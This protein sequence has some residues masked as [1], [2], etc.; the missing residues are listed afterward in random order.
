MPIKSDELYLA[1]EFGKFLKKQFGEDIVF[2]HCGAP[3]RAG[4]FQRVSVIYKHELV[5]VV[6]KDD[7]SVMYVGRVPSYVNPKTGK[8]DIALEQH[9]F[10]EHKR[11]D[12]HLGIAFP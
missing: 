6:S 11:V 2:E 12:G 4:Q 7:L 1:P 10:G 9:L 3:Y 5:G 8:E